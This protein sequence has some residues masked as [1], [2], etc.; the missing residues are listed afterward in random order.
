MNTQV[1]LVT[2]AELI[3]EILDDW[4]E[5]GESFSLYN[6]VEE[7]RNRGNEEKGVLVLDVSYGS[8]DGVPWAR[9]V[10]EYTEDLKKKVI[11]VLDD[12]DFQTSFNG[13]YRVY[14]IVQDST[15]NISSVPPAIGV[16]TSVSQLVAKASPATPSTR[17]VVSSL[18][19]V[20]SFATNQLAKGASPT[21][22][23]IQSALKRGKG[24]VSI[25]GKKIRSFLESK[26]F[27]IGAGPNSVATVSK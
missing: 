1:K 18:D 6:V 21:V 26:G 4:T 13:S 27:S 25:P 3:K 8:F 14:T 16:P 22:K 10:L 15:P 17:G 9:P 24:Y 23:S 11:S 20:L 7:M 5:T 19:D 2:K 12:Y